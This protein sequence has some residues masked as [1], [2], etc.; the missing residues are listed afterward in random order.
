[1]TTTSGAIGLRNKLAPVLEESFEKFAGA[2]LFDA[3]DDLGPVVAGRL[4]EDAGAVLDAAAL[5]VIGT[6]IEPADAGEADGGG[7]HRA[8]LQGDIEIAAIE[9][10]LAGLGASLT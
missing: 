3:A 9:P 8:R 5:G 1:M 7:A 6:K 4:G 2:D 10:G